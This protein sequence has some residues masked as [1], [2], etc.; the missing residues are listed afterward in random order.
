[1]TMTPATAADSIPR[2]DR[3]LL[4]R[5]TIVI[6]LGFLFVAAFARLNLVYGRKFFDVSGP[7]RWIWP[8]VDISQ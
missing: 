6:I 5:L 2:A 4:V 7:A 1:M 8:N 3:Q